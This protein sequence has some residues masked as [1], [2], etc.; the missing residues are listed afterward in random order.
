MI[1]DV[2]SLKLALASRIDRPDLSTAIDEAVDAATM[3]MSREFR[4]FDQEAR[5]TVT[6]ATD[7]F[8]VLP[9]DYNGM[10]TLTVNDKIAEYYT[11][12]YF[13]RV[14][15]TGSVVSR[16]IYT[17]VDGRL[18]L[19]PAPSAESPASLVMV[20]TMRLEELSGA[21]S[22]NWLL[23]N[24]PDIY[25]AASMSFLCRHMKDWDASERW[26]RVTR[27]LMAQAIVASRRRR[28]PSASLVIRNA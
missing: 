18:Q 21:A 9:T 12:E 6:S 7:E 15:D 4:L 22:T 17:V 27:D 1:T 10:K 20:Y 2:T 3:W 8:T 14:K 11:L 13:Q 25:E 24:H 28:F 5:V 19:Y 16:S 26:E 23:T